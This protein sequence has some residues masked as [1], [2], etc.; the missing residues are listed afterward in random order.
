MQTKG[1]GSNL[2]GGKLELCGCL[3]INAEKQIKVRI[4]KKERKIT[5][6][7]KKCRLDRPYHPEVKETPIIIPH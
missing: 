4:F 6:S 2:F 3:S 5:I 1:S 7:G